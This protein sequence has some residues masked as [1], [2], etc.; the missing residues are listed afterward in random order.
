MF[1]KEKKYKKIISL[2]LAFF[3]LF[4]TIDWVVFATIV[5][6]AEV[7]AANQYKDFNYTGG[8]QEFT[9]NKDGIYKL[10][11]WGAQGANY[12]S[13][14]LGGKGGYTY[15]TLNLK[16]GDVIKVAV[17][18][19]GTSNAGGYNGGGAVKKGQG[20]GGKTDVYL[21]GTLIMLAGGGGGASSKYAG[22]VGGA[23]LSSSIG[24]T[25]GQTGNVAGG[26]AGAVGGAYGHVHVLINNATNG[27]GCYCQR[28]YHTHSGKPGSCWS[29]YTYVSCSTT[30]HSHSGSSSSGGG[31][32]GQAN[33]SYGSWSSST[34]NGAPRSCSCGGYATNK[35]ASYRCSLCGSTASCEYCS[36]CGHVFSGSKKSGNHCSRVSSYSR[37]CGMNE[38]SHGGG[39]YSTGYNQIC[40]KSTSTIE[41]EAVTC[42]LSERA[43]TG[44]TSYIA[45]S[46]FLSTGSSAGIQSGNGKVR[47]TLINGIPL[48][49]NVCVSSDGST[50][51][52]LKEIKVNVGKSFDIY[53]NFTELDGDTL[54]IQYKLDSNDWQTLATYSNSKSSVNF[55]K[56]ID[57]TNYSKGTHNISVRAFDSYGFNAKNTYNL[58][59][60]INT[61][62]TLDN[63]TISKTTSSGVDEIF[64]NKGD[65]FYLLGDVFDADG[66]EVFVEYKIGETGTY[67]QVPVTTQNGKFYGKVTTEK[68]LASGYHNIYVR[69]YDHAR[70]SAQFNEA[71]NVYAKE[72]SVSIYVNYPPVFESDLKIGTDKE[73]ATIISSLKIPYQNDLYVSGSVY[74]EELHSMQISYEF[75]ALNGTVYKR[76]EVNNI[77]LSEKNTFKSFEQVLNTEDLP[78][79]EYTF[80]IIATDEKNQPSEI[81]S[82][83]IMINNPANIQNLK[84]TMANKWNGAIYRNEVSKQPITLSFDV[85]DLDNITSLWGDDVTYTI[86]I[87]GYEIANVP[88]SKSTLASKNGRMT[89]TINDLQNKLG[90]VL[91]DF[92]QTDISIEIIDGYGKT[93]ST[94]DKDTNGN[95][96]NIRTNHNPIISDFKISFGK[97]NLTGKNIYDR[98]QTGHTS[99][100][101]KPEFTW[102]LT[103]TDTN[104]G[105]SI[106]S[107]ALQYSID[108]G[109]TWVDVCS[110]GI[111]TSTRNLKWLNDT[112]YTRTQV[113]FRLVAVDYFGVTTISEY[114]RDDNIH[115]QKE[116]NPNAPGY[117]IISNSNYSK[118]FVND[119]YLFAWGAALDENVYDGIAQYVFGYIPNPSLP[120]DYETNFKVIEKTT[121]F[122]TSKYVNFQKM[123][124]TSNDI[125]FGVYA[126]DKYGEKSPIKKF[127]VTFNE[128][129]IPNKVNFSLDNFK[130]KS[131]DTLAK[132]YLFNNDIYTIKWD[133]AGDGDENDY[134]K[135]WTIYYKNDKN[136]S[137]WKVFMKTSKREVSLKLS[138][139]DEESISELTGSLSFKIVATDTFGG[140]SVDSNIVALNYVNDPKA[141]TLDNL[142]NFLVGEADKNGQKT[143]FIISDDLGVSLIKL[144]Y[145]GIEQEV[146]YNKDLSVINNA[147]VSNEGKTVTIDNYLFEK[148]G[149]Y[150]LYLE[151]IYGT[152]TTVLIRIDTIDSMVPIAV[153]KPNIDNSVLT[154]ESV[155]I[156]INM[157]DNGE[158]SELNIVGINGTTYNKTINLEGNKKSSYIL[159]VSSNGSYLFEVV[160]KAGNRFSSTYTVTNIYKQEANIT[161]DYQNN[162]ARDKVSFNVHSDINIPGKLNLGSW[163]I[164]GDGQIE[165]DVIDNGTTVKVTVYDNGDYNFV[166]TDSWGNVSKKH[167]VKV[168]NIVKGDVETTV[169]YL[170]PYE[171][172]INK[173]QGANPDKISVNTEKFYAELINA[174]FVAPTEFVEILSNDSSNYSY[175]FA[176]ITIKDEFKPIG[177]L[178]DYFN[179]GKTEFFKENTKIND[180]EYFCHSALFK[181]SADKTI[182][183]FFTK[184]IFDILCMKK[185][186]IDSLAAQNPIKIN[187][188]ISNTNPTNQDIEAIFYVEDG[189]FFEDDTFYQYS[190]N[191]Q[192]LSYYDKFEW[193]SYDAQLNTYEILQNVPQEKDRTAFKIN[194]DENLFIN[195]WAKNNS[196]DYAYKDLTITNIDKESPI[197]N[198]KDYSTEYAYDSLTVEAYTQ[199][200]FL[201]ANVLENKLKEL[202]SGSDEIL[203]IIE[204][205]NISKNY[206]ISNDKHY[207]Y[208]T[209]TENSGNYDVFKF[210]A[211]D[212]ADNI[213]FSNT[214]KIENIYQQSLEF[215]VEYKNESGLYEELTDEIL[216][217]L[218]TNNIL[219][220]KISTKDYEGKF[221]DL[222]NNDCIISD[223]NNYLTKSISENGE[224]IFCAIDNYNNKVYYTLDIADNVNRFPTILNISKKGNL[225]SF[226][227]YTSSFDLEIV[228]KDY[229][230]GNFSIYNEE[231]IVI[232]NADNTSSIK[233]TISKNGIYNVLFEDVYGNSIME[234][235]EIVGIFGEN[236]APTLTISNYKTK[237]TNQSVV[238]VVSVENGKFD[239][240]TFSNQENVDVDNSN[241]NKWILTFKENADVNIIAT[242]LFGNAPV[243]E[244]ISISNID[245]INPTEP[246]KVELIDNSTGL[247]NLKFVDNGDDGFGNEYISYEISDGINVDS[248]NLRISK[249][250]S[251]EDEFNDGTLYIKYKSID[252]AGN[253]STEI[254][255]EILSD[256]NKVLDFNSFYDGALIE[257]TRITSIIDNETRQNELEQFMSSINPF[258]DGF[259]TEL[260]SYIN[261]L[262]KTFVINKINTL[263]AFMD[264]STVGDVDLVN[265]IEVYFDRLEADITDNLF[266]PELKVL[267]NSLDDSS[268]RSN[269]LNKYLYYEELIKTIFIDETSTEFAYIDTN[270]NI[271]NPL[272]GYVKVGDI[273]GTYNA[274]GMFIKGKVD[275]DYYYTSAGN[276]VKLDSTGE[277]YV[278][279]N[280][281]KIS[282]I[283]GL[284]N[285]KFYYNEVGELVKFR[286]AN[287]FFDFE[288]KWH[289]REGLS[290]VEKPI[291]DDNNENN[292]PSNPEEETKPTYI[293][294]TSITLSESTVEMFIG[295]VL[296]ITY[297]L[298]PVGGNIRDTI[299]YWSTN[300]SSV[301]KVTDGNLIA[302]GKGTAIITAKTDNGL[303]ATID[304]TV[305][306]SIN[307]E[308]PP[309]ED[310]EGVEPPIKYPTIDDIID[311]KPNEDDL[312]ASYSAIQI[313]SIKAASM[314]NEEIKT[315]SFEK[316]YKDGY[317]TV[318]LNELGSISENILK[319]AKDTSMNIGIV[320]SK[321]ILILSNKDIYSI[322]SLGLTQNG[323]GFNLSI[324]GNSSLGK[325]SKLILMGNS[326]NVVYYNG[327]IISS[328][329]DKELGALVVYNPLPGNYVLGTKA[330]SVYTYLDKYGMTIDANGNL[331]YADVIKACYNCLQA[332]DF[333]TLYSNIEKTSDV[334]RQVS[335]LQKFGILDSSCNYSSDLISGYEAYDIVYLTLSNKIGGDLNYDTTD[336]DT[337]SITLGTLNNMV[338]S[339][340]EIEY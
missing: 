222:D 29:S 48:L 155:D 284:V 158:L 19:Q 20:G 311:N 303:I 237:P 52:N 163:S 107:L 152:S 204:N 101:Y 154:N 301:V 173:N 325:N 212:L 310:I 14:Y 42:S 82:Y 30:V 241:P 44:G 251:I 168:S 172:Y 305:S 285:G 113:M 31:C 335:I 282:T 3:V 297:S 1:N 318:L 287:G 337:S 58:V 151:D 261:P 302:V 322:S 122:N 145:A 23:S 8:F 186:S 296:R 85:V 134:V 118:Y 265:K 317:S 83:T 314:N 162:W 271:I 194:I 9:V 230:L 161:N 193:I 258:I 300:N 270:G 295:D 268:L 256:N 96:I 146:F 79:G 157:S 147:I 6:A 12:S 108:N 128:N 195:I 27:E 233:T 95:G 89:V 293:D 105:D 334:Y 69:V 73:S 84:L 278:D 340:V 288:G 55:S 326:N 185:A 167:T 78:S 127:N 236:Y 25:T 123:G 171:E 43:S 32:Y 272:S 40:G 307:S 90:P 224:Y 50:T 56:T 64:I 308:N 15:G 249:L 243:S 156:T 223:N 299:V 26:G 338:K 191:G 139:L 142:N 219:E 182:T 260:D 218:R 169:K 65:S 220:I 198:V 315:S 41:Q 13:S 196:G 59:V 281:N 177:T 255:E 339:I 150:S 235:V 114:G 126:V 239:E 229:R 5:N 257:L 214:I 47:L 324:V 72:S 7:E 35:S 232:S 213:T 199:D 51:S 238:I 205:L 103:E 112:N 312:Y 242:N 200:Y 74:D 136:S 57:T 61:A 327:E 328:T 4:T 37:N 294:P 106:T 143:K 111:S 225:D 46:A 206:K 34:S 165:Y 62:P 97:D 329:Y 286:P 149:N 121:D 36:R 86:F 231:G 33:Y 131:S 188:V 153:I 306:K 60:K 132:G 244:T 207:A 24:S 180:N 274:S 144:S 28:I 264:G 253:Y 331:S 280:K 183:T 252:F 164:D 283:N 138:N 175:V 279:A 289:I 115:L 309:Q 140:N 99:N 80:S 210:I 104:W 45:T 319:N 117:L 181:F 217:N 290:E 109:S 192:N 88:V 187:S 71:V 124:F 67:K 254:Q 246:S 189:Y 75:K 54:T 98:L 148:N 11:A 68:T 18:S 316:V 292:N 87:G 227:Y 94:I 273:Y 179:D 166:F 221:Y 116:T 91:E 321:A 304:V 208:M 201:D 133:D 92:S 21:N 276:R 248:A 190:E 22:G 263:E 63:L 262:Q 259:K 135:T 226:G 10:E 66:D 209:F 53:G 298:G 245:K 102:D 120:D 137:D 203:Q 77:Q 275:K 159:T 197:I 234:K 291:E 216:K 184:D 174:G 277:T 49:N 110:Q 313:G 228:S 323:N 130:D 125:V 211:S 330:T 178:I 38:H 333:G 81:K 93:I 70:N 119:D 247:I 141:P 202:Y 176:Y 250:L 332:D 76:P 320:N 17:G 16:K 160:D 269:Y 100:E 267:I 170:V 129:T 240:I 215:I 2:I 39:C 266:M 336:F